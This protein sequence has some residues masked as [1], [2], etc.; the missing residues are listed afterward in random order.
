MDTYNP[1][2]GILQ[3]DS[4]GINPSKVGIFGMYLSG[5]LERGGEKENE[6]GFRRLRNKS[7][8]LNL[9]EGL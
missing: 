4:R 7:P 6:L 1:D 9:K 3:L 8:S 2:Y 5:W